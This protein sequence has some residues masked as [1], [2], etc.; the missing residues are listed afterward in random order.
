MNN[1]PHT[2][3]YSWNPWDDMRLLSQDLQRL[4]TGTGGYA[5]GGREFPAVNIWAN[6]EEA[7]LTAELPGVAPETLDVAV[8]NDTVTIKGT[9][10]APAQQEGEQ[11]LRQER[12]YGD[13]ARSFALPFRV[14]PE[15]VSARAENGVLTVTLPRAE[16]EK[17]RRIAIRD[18]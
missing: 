13:F 5:A 2:L 14:N 4:L 9:R 18:R 6:D 12:A 1:W 8:Q 11:W 7:R 16:E 17:P 15:Q 3:R 10:A